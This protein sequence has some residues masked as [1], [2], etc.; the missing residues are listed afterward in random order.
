MSDIEKIEHLKE[1]IIEMRRQKVLLE[2]DAAQ[3][4]GVETR[5][6]NIA[7][8]NNPG[9]YI[10]ELS[11]PEKNEPVENFHRFDKLKHSMVNLKAFA[12]KRLYIFAT[13]LPSDR[14]HSRNFLKNQRAVQE[15]QR[16]ISRAR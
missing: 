16:V 11:K 7:V 6:D 10:I 5:D 9:G 15:H 12:G 14:R 1:I 13:M 4:C 2:S 8:T 3:I